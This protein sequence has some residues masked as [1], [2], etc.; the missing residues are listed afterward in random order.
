MRSGLAMVDPFLDVLAPA[1]HVAVHHLGLFRDPSPLQAVGHYNDIATASNPATYGFA[2]DQLIAT[3]ATV[4]A[5]IDSLNLCCSMIRRERD[6]RAN[7]SR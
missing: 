7:H 2:V 1:Q 3:G 4:S 6:P 5:A